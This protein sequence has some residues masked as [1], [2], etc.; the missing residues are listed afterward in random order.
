MRKLETEWVLTKKVSLLSPF[1]WHIWKN[2]QTETVQVLP[3]KLPDKDSH[4]FLGDQLSNAWLL[5]EMSQDTI[6]P[7]GHDLRLSI[8]IFL[9]PSSDP[10]FWGIVKVFALAAPLK[11]PKEVCPREADCSQ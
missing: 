9:S 1:P 4:F 7:Q 2:L 8:S 6:K 3:H 11:E 10:G 5:H